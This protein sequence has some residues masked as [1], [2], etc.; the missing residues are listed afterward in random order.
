MD[1]VAAAG[2]VTAVERETLGLCGTT[3]MGRVLDLLKVGDAPATLTAEQEWQLRGTPRSM[4]DDLERNMARAAADADKFHPLTRGIAYAAAMLRHEGNP[5]SEELLGDLLDVST[6]LTEMD[7]SSGRNYYPQL[8]RLFRGQFPK[9]AV[10]AMSPLEGEREISPKDVMGD[11]K[12]PVLTIVAYDQ[13]DPTQAGGLAAGA[14]ATGVIHHALQASSTAFISGRIRD[15]KEATALGVVVDEGGA[16]AAITTA[17]ATAATEGRQHGIAPLIVVTSRSHLDE[18]AG[19]K[20]AATI[21]G[22]S[23]ISIHFAPD[24][25]TVTGL[26]LSFGQEVKYH[27]TETVSKDWEGRGIVSSS[28]VAHNLASGRFQRPAQPPSRAGAGVRPVERASLSA[29]AA[30][31]G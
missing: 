1:I 19:P 12:S 28:S 9:A 29:R 14:F 22:A 11:G 21:A 6:Q 3:G 31:P 7:A 10:R 15:N 17:L 20:S 23:P 16:L 13:T 30:L 25:N 4:V 26:S 18:V 24:A 2:H 27:A 8:L 5:V